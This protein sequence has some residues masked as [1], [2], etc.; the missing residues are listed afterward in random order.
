MSIDPTGGG[1]PCSGENTAPAWPDA[2]IRRQ[3]I[4]IRDALRHRR[5]ARD[6]CL[7][8]RLYDEHCL[9]GPAREARDGVM[10]SLRATSLCW[11]LALGL[12]ASGGDRGS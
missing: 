8:Q 4:A 5:Q 6:L 2:C 12:D 7:Q 11:R 1:Q 10:Q 9:F 3:A